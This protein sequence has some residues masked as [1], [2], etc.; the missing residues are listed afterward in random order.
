MDSQGL[1]TWLP[2]TAAKA[3]LYS[4]FL[5]WSNWE[6]IGLFALKQKQKCGYTKSQSY[7][8]RRISILS[9]KTAPLG[10]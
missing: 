8:L 5:I 7:L 10:Y 3:A 6:M 1:Q 9:C 2:Q 4:L